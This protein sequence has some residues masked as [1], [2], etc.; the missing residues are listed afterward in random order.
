[1]TAFRRTAPAVLRIAAGIALLLGMAGGGF[2]WRESEVKRSFAAGERALARD[3][4][5]AAIAAYGRAL[6]LAPGR[7]D[8][9]HQIGVAH[10]LRGELDAAIVHLEEAERLFP[11][12]EGRADLAR[13]RADR[14]KA[15][16]DQSR[17]G[18]D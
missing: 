14:R 13:A 8:I 1:M 6:A 2:A 12:A 18:E 7:A 4:F 17:R 16:A 15:A 11:T 5:G 3:D 10:A 9:H